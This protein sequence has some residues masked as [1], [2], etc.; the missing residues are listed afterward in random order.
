MDSDRT[1]PSEPLI[2]TYVF[3]EHLIQKFKSII[4]NVLFIYYYALKLMKYRYLLIVYYY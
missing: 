4:E 3:K 2:D 1:E